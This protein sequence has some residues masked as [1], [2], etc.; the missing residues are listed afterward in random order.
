M[1][2][3]VAGPGVL[4]RR[5]RARLPAADFEVALFHG[6]I[7]VSLPAAPH[8]ACRG[9]LKPDQAGLASQLLDEM[10]ELFPNSIISS[11]ADGEG[12]AAPQ[13]GLGPR[14]MRGQ[15]QLEAYVEPSS[16]ARSDGCGLRIAN[17]MGWKG[18]RLFVARRSFFPPTLRFLPT[19]QRSTSTAGTTPPWWP[20][21]PR[22]T[23]SSRRRWCG[24]WRASRSRCAVVVCCGGG[25]VRAA[26]G[27]WWRGAAAA[28]LHAAGAGSPCHCLPAPSRA[29]GP[30]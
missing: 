30:A 3:A 18:H 19:L 11:G 8:V 5:R 4:A 2:A 12:R 21:T 22:T 9:Q 26:V 14:H 25:G 23:P 15:G 24:S 13:G 7:F 20:K 29:E 1:P 16:G 28:G 27:V 17:E 6:Q 10:M